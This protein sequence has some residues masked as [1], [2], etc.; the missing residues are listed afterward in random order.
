MELMLGDWLL[1]GFA[2]S[3]AL[4]CFF[5][6]CWLL[7][8]FKCF[9]HSKA[10]SPCFVMNP[11]GTVGLCPCC[12]TSIPIAGRNATTTALSACQKKNDDHDHDSDHEYESHKVFFYKGSDVYHNSLCFH[13]KRRGTGNFYELNPCKH[14][15][16]KIER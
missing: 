11:A 15:V 16:G 3:L 8:C 1:V 2:S 5:G 6:A 13:L 10:S 7:Q 9:H 12:K 4:N 14:C